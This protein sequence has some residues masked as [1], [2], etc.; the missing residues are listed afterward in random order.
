MPDLN[1]NAK[2]CDRGGD[3]DSLHS[4]HGVEQTPGESKPVKQSKA[5][6][7]AQPGPTAA[8][9]GCEQVLEGN[10]DN[11]CGYHRF[12]DPVGKPHHIENRE[13]KSDRVL[14]G[15]A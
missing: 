4:F 2:G 5:E 7:D 13:R 6:R 15:G 10:E 8:A 12:H 3:G 11:A 1:P 9:R 14:P